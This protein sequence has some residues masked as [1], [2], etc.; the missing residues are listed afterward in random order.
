MIR[1]VITPFN[2]LPQRLSLAG[3]SRASLRQSL[4]QS[5]CRA[6]IGRRPKGVHDLLTGFLLIYTQPRRNRCRQRRTPAG[7]QPHDFIAVF[8][9]GIHQLW[10][11]K[12]A[13]PGGNKRQRLRRASL[14]FFLNFPQQRCF[15][16]IQRFCCRTVI[17]NL[18]IRRNS[19]FQRKPFQN[20]LAKAVNGLNLHSPRRIQQNGKQPP[21]LRHNLPVRP[22]AAQQKA[23][24]PAQIIIGRH[25]PAA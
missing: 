6:E 24:F 1:G 4:C 2:S 21:R 14:R 10:K 15:D 23:Q 8:G 11:G 13:D 7:Q 18:K 16:I 17:H 20:F 5:Q 22:A 25:R 12:F 19:R 9:Q 3:V